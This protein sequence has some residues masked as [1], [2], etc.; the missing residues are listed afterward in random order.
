[1]D[2]YYYE[3]EEL[4]DHN[5]NSIRDWIKSTSGIKLSELKV[6]DLVFHN[7][8]PIRTGNGVYIFK[9]NNIP[10]YVGNC[11][12]R[13]FVERIPAHFDVRQNGWFNSLLVTL[14][15]RTFNRK[16]KEDKT[17]INLTQ[18]AKLAFENLDLVLINFSVYDKLAINRLEDYLRIT[19]K[20]LNGFKHKK[21]N[22]ENITIR[23]YLEYNK[24]QN[25]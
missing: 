23:E 21:L 14:I 20:P 17:D 1:M 7:D 8:L 10:L 24:I 22:Q 19:L 25:L 13:N 16:L 4:L 15:K 9:E 11:V 3:L 5:P 6:K 12:A 18:S 2:N